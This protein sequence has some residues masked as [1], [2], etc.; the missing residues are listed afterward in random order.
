MQL[1]NTD[2][3]F[4]K[5]ESTNGITFLY[6]RK[7][8]FLYEMIGGTF[9]PFHK[10]NTYAELQARGNFTDQEMTLLRL[11]LGKIRERR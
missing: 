8:G 11:S 3:G 5:I 6:N 9:T 4:T 1:S 2:K 10:I 7:A